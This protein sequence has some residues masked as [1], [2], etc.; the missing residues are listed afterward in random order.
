MIKNKHNSYWVLDKK[1]R[2]TPDQ[3]IGGAIYDFIENMSIKQTDGTEKSMVTIIHDETGMAYPT[4]RRVFCGSTDRFI[5]YQRVLTAISQWVSSH[6]YNLLMQRIIQLDTEF[7]R[8]HGDEFLSEQRIS[9]RPKKKHVG[10]E[11]LP[12]E[13]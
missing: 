11:Y 5:H 9:N 1:D 2:L 13:G 10:E 8:G 3:I 12:P 6:D 7:M 4:M